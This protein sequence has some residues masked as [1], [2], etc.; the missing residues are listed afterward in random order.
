V[1]QSTES[2]RIMY[3][4]DVTLTNDTDDTVDVVIPRGTIFEGTRVEGG[5]PMQNLAIG[6]DYS[7]SLGRRMSVTLH[8]EGDCINGSFP[9]PRNW[10]MRPTVFALP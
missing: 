3:R 1:N 5:W 7:I 9:A 10:P 4:I 2:E 6:R 8:L